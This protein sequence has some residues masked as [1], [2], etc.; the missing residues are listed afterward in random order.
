MTL[1]PKPLSVSSFTVDS[2]SRAYMFG[3]QLLN[4]KE[5]QDALKAAQD[6]PELK[7]ALRTLVIE[8]YK[9]CINGGSI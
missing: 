3:H 4:K 9:I 6:D 7:G 2:R 1:S 8:R 5:L